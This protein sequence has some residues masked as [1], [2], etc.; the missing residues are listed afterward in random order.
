MSFHFRLL[1]TF[2]Y[3]QNFLMQILLISDVHYKQINVTKKQKLQS[4]MD[5]PKKRA[6]VGTKQRKQTDKTK[7][8][9]TQKR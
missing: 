3:Y 8:N 6:V 4:R 5:N 1:I 9:S 2:W 7:Q